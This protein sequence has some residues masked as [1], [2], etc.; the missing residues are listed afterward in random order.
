MFVDF[1]ARLE[2]L[3][4]RPIPG[5]PDL[6]QDALSAQLQREQF[7]SWVRHS[8]VM[9]AIGALSGGCLLWYLAADL[10]DPWLREAAACLAASYLLMVG[11]SV[12]I[13][14]RNNRPLDAQE[15]LATL[16]LKLGILRTFIGCSWGAMLVVMNEVANVDQRCLLF[17]VGV[18]LLSTSVFGGSFV[19]GLTVWLPIM[20][21]FFISALII[22][23]QIGAAP[24]CCLVLYGVLT[25]F[26]IY[27]LSKKL[28]DFTLNGFELKSRNE[29]IKIVLNDFE[30]VAS[31]WL[32][33]TDA[34]MTLVNLSPRL[35]SLLFPD[36]PPL[37]ETE[38][39][40]DLRALVLSSVFLGDGEEQ[41]D[42]FVQKLAARQPFSRLVLPVT[43]D[44]TNHWWMLSGKP[45]FNIKG[46][47][48][49][50]HGVGSDVTESHGFTQRIEYIARHDALTGTL[51]RSRFNE[52][53]AEK[54]ET[55]DDAEMGFCLISFD[56]DNFKGVNDSFGH[57]IGD[58]LLQ[59][60]AER[61]TQ[62]VNFGDVVARIGGDEFH[63]LS[64]CETKEDGMELAN[65]IIRELNR[66]VVIHDTRLAT[67]ASAGL[68]YA[69]WDVKDPVQML[70]QSDLALYHAKKKGRGL[71]CQ[72]D[73]MIEFELQVR[74]KLEADLQAAL[75]YNQFELLFQPVLCLQTSKIVGVEALIRWQHPT[76][77]RIFPDEFIATAERTGLIE[78][79]GRWVIT[80]AC[81]VAASL[82]SHITMSINL[83]P[84][85]LRNPKIVE[86]TQKTIQITGLD[87][88]RIEFEITESSVLDTEGSSLA[89]FDALSRLGIKFALDDF[90]TGHSSLSLLHRLKFDRLKIDRSF[91]AN[92][93]TDAVNR[94]L[95]EKT[96]ELSQALDIAVTVEGI[97]TEA[98]AAF[99]RK[100]NGIH[101]QGY[102]FG[103][104]SRIGEIVFDLAPD[105]PARPEKVAA[106]RSN[107]VALDRRLRDG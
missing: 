99:L 59:I 9:Y 20:T 23:P 55:L 92:M 78:P 41:I 48:I 62:S 76:R 65:R 96:I 30:E 27:D 36:G 10:Y 29:I 72:Y 44:S 1:S 81:R 45:R 70:K 31:D 50:Y 57:A 69:P 61:I 34:E 95:V 49:G 85:Q 77:G 51:N 24:L 102:L 25:L 64:D 39:R 54:F 82:P 35:S 37:D 13:L 93:L 88:R 97:E 87:P 33:E 94:T 17:G 11:V 91:T 100:Y 38:A 86:L 12:R 22:F 14:V 84:I 18:A 89:T 16:R 28:R 80:E 73:D 47:F 2:S 52:I 71:A 21:G 63:V 98:Q 19:Y 103:R 8:F 107:I 15:H 56:L 101:A 4:G 32:W 43:I 67:G 60:V 79:I 68:S 7:M 83:S 5:R 75:T 74:A 104:P 90:G 26:S 46:E 66:P 3:F 106:G 58:E 40:V 6:Q 105:Q 53:L 42:A